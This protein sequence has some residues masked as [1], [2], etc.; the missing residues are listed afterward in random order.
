MH[1]R[2]R[3]IA[4]LTLVAGLVLSPATGKAQDLEPRRWTPM[5]PGL[6]VLGIGAALTSGDVLFD[7]ALQVQDA[8]VEARTLAVSYVRSFRLAGKLAR[9]DFV[10]PWQNASWSGRLQG[11]PARVTRVGLADPTVRLSVLLA[12]AT[13]D[14]T[15]KS[16][17]VIGAALA[18]SLPLGEYFADKLLNLGQNRFIF[19]PQ[20]GIVHS[21]G[22]WSYEL[23]GNAY[24]FTDNDDF[25]GGVTREQDP[26]FSV[27]GHVI[28]ALGKPGHWAA[29]SLGF[30]GYGRSIIDAGPVDD[31]QRIFLSALSYGVPLG[32]RQGLKFAYVRNR[33]NTSK[34]ANTDSLAISWSTRF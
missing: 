22:P 31:S 34:G 3:S 26:L 24:L 4:T 6:T 28:R 13:P 17:T 32:T 27:E 10:L 25:Y 8:E 11:E 5:P 20:V 23:T 12:G 14:A 19:R 18:V 30:G 2:T 33:T 21:R 9:A 7:P 1:K 29:L 15:S 16:H